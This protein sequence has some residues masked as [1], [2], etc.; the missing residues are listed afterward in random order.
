MTAAVGFPTLRL[1]RFSVDKWSLERQGH[2][3]F[4]APG[5]YQSLQV[6]PGKMARH[7][8]KSNPKSKKPNSSKST[9]KA[10]RPQQVKK[11]HK[12]KPR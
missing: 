3:E 4:L 2:A 7:A 8:P 10:L 5:D 9:R 11:N 12:P 1:I 6:D